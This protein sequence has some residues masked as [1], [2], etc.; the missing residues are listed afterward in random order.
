MKFWNY[1]E[2][3]F[4][5]QMCQILA[6]YYVNKYRKCMRKHYNAIN[7]KYSQNK[8]KKNPETWPIF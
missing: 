4:I 1:K 5:F 8:N 7:K 6:F 3:G 2:K